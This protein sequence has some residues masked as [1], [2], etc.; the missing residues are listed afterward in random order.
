MN[1]KS[2]WLVHCDFGRG[3]WDI[4]ASICACYCIVIISKILFNKTKY[5]SKVFQFLGKHSLLL[6]CIH[7]IE[8]SFL[9][10]NIIILNLFGYYSVFY[11]IIGKMV[12]NIGICFIIC[13]IKTIIDNEKNKRLKKQEFYKFK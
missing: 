10:W 9:R 3:I 13:K 12:L 2:F 6:L 1:F 5:I 7:A 4:W 8:L 11:I